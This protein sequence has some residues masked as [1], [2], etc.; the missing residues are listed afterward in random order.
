MSK[1]FIRVKSDLDASIGVFITNYA[2]AEF[3]V[4]RSLLTLLELKETGYLLIEGMPPKVKSKKLQI[5][6]RE[7]KPRYKSVVGLLKR[8][9]EITR[10]RDKIAH[11]NYSIDENQNVEMLNAFK[12]PKKLFHERIPFNPV[13][14]RDLAYWLQE[15]G[16][17][18][19]YFDLIEPETDEINRSVNDLLQRFPCIP[20]AGN[21]NP[22]KQ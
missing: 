19:Y 12:N 21:T 16:H 11:W 10:F 5:A 8:F 7:F 20:K 18:V 1:K 2:A 15:F 6:M 14:V 13:E 17:S 9:D 4:S 3:S 22:Y